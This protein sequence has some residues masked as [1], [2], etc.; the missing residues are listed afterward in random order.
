MSR[1]LPSPRP[2]RF[3]S[4]NEDHLPAGSARKMTGRTR[5]KGANNK[6]VK[7]PVQ[8]RG[9]HQR[10]RLLFA[11]RQTFQRLGYAD[12]RVSDIVRKAGVA[13]G[14]FYTY[15]DS[16]EDV[17]MAIATEV[18]ESLA[19]TLIGDNRAAQDASSLRAR[20]PLYID[21]F[22]GVADVIDVV[23]QASA[24]HPDVKNLHSQFRD[25]FVSLIERSVPSGLA[26][27]G[28]RWNPRPA[29]WAIYGAL[30]ALLHAWLLDRDKLT[31]DDVHAVVGQL[32]EAWLP[33]DDAPVAAK[34]AKIR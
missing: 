27:F 14:T 11:A 23:E 32:L 29:A 13:H 8:A 17:L 34:K 9:R 4:L 2:A 18:F 20:I 28:T 21:G 3:S 22:E 30:D 19:A 26:G 1:W 12:S 15:F 7:R 33:V 16:R 5:K 25:R 31:Q 24:M 6:F 10:E